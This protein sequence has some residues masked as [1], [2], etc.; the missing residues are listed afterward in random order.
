M[1]SPPSV[2]KLKSGARNPCL[3]AGMCPWVVEP[4]STA[5]SHIQNAPAVKMNMEI[6]IQIFVNLCIASCELL[7]YSKE[8]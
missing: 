3:G 5:L 2:D 1:G 6:P 8:K 4:D 7:I